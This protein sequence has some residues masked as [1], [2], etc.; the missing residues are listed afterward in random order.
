MPV[1]KFLIDECVMG[2]KHV[3]IM[4][5]MLRKLNHSYTIE[6]VIQKFSPGAQDAEWIPEIANEPDWV[7]ISADRGKR[8]KGA[9]LPLL[10]KEFSLTHVLMTSS[11]SQMSSEGKLHAI[12]GNWS[13]LIL[14]LNNPI[15]SQY[16]LK[17]I[18]GENGVV[19]LKH[20]HKFQPKPPNQT[21]LF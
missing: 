15:G 10:C 6:H 2:T 18:G 17:K 4:E 11:V 14:V 21:D 5:E 16:L 9:K 1:P 12:V 7:I 8:G 19:A 20:N 13:E 3:R